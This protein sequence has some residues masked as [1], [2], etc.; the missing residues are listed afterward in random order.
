M[1]E[2]SPG[3]CQNLR[4]QRHL[5]ERLGRQHKGQITPHPTLQRIK[6]S[7]KESVGNG[8]W[9]LTKRKKQKENKGKVQTRPKNEA[10]SHSER[11]LKV[12]HPCAHE[13]SC[14]PCEEQYTSGTWPDVC[15]LRTNQFSEDSQ[16]SNTKT[17]SIPSKQNTAPNLRISPRSAGSQRKIP[18][19][20][21]SK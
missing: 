4:Q 20:S 1:Q 3:S 2:V 18:C 15:R 9:K 14:D 6:G 7:C 8:N 17:R 10:S 13:L 5:S 11:V 16:I 12:S 19:T 21:F